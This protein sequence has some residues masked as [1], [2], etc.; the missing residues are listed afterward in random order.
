MPAGHEP[1]AAPIVASA[2]GERRAV[3]D[4][5]SDAPRPPARSGERNLIELLADLADAE[6]ALVQ[7]RG[8][9][10]GEIVDAPAI[11]A[12]VAP[13]LERP[14]HVAEILALLESG[15]LREQSET[16][17][18]ASWA[19][20]DALTR[21]EY[22]ACRALF[23]ALTGYNDPG[24]GANPFLRLADGRRVVL[25]VVLALPRIAGDAREYLLSC[26][27]EARYRASGKPIFDGSFLAAF[28]EARGAFADEEALFFRL[29]R[30]LKESLSPE[31]LRAL[32]GVLA[33]P[34]DPTAVRERIESLFE[35]GDAAFA[36][37][38]ARS[39]F[40]AAEADVRLAIATAVATHGDPLEAVGF[41]TERIEDTKSWS[42]LWF[43][44]GQ[45]PQ[46]SAALEAVY[47]SL[48]SDEFAGQGGEASERA[49][50]ACLSGMLAADAERMLEIFHQEGSPRIRG[51]ALMTLAFRDGYAP[52]LEHLEL[53]ERGFAERS[54]EP[55]KGV[56]AAYTLAAKAP[57]GSP[58]RARAIALIERL[59]DGAESPTVREQAARWLAELGG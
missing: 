53:L 55:T 46:G 1:A 30:I 7:D 11:V 3:P 16:G 56:S 49:R 18:Q 26:V 4:E 15:L 14:E 48:Y 13:I 51:Q 36:M 2:E 32:D 50:E 45:R 24:D 59:R 52:K 5:R 35:A 17:D 9:Q 21:L 33:D 6:E 23:W 54:I 8:A 40:E 22:A 42:Q 43:S 58:L 41:L 38:V 47:A 19:R 10:P 31:E 29:L 25:D 27:G 12:A 44:L 20:L 39:S 34:R 28:L 37:E 57:A